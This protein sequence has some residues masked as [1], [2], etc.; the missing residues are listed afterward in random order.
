VWNEPD[1]TNDRAYGKVELKNKAD[2]VLPLLEKTFAWARS[3]NP[4]QP[5]TSAVWRGDWSSHEAMPPLQKV[6]IDE[7]DVITFHNYE[8]SSDFSMR[9]KWLE[10]YERP[11][12]CTEYMARPNGS[13]FE[14]ILPIAKEYNIGMFNWGFV[15][16]KTQTKYPWD[17]WDIK[18]SSE[19]KL[20]FH[21]VLRNDGTPYRAEEVELIKELTAVPEYN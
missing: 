9:V 19:P 16:G 21:E 12:I 11:L 2:Y 8:D 5:V 1:N 14:T 13:T 10:R 7:S 20:W 15:D 17:S 4:S 3:V 18:Y 6:Q